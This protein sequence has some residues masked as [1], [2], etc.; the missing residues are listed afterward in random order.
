MQPPFSFD[1]PRPSEQRLQLN[2]EQAAIVEL[3]ASGQ[4][5][6][7]GGVGGTG[8][9]VVFKY[10]VDMLR[11]MGKSVV[12]CAS[13]GSAAANVNGVTSNCLFGLRPPRVRPGD[14]GDYVPCIEATRFAMKN[15]LKDADAL[16]LDEA[17][18]H[19]S[20]MFAQMDRRARRLRGRATAH[21]PFGGMQVVI[22]GDFAQMPPVGRGVNPGTI[23][24]CESE[25]FRRTVGK[26]MFILKQQ[27]RQADDPEYAEAL[28][29]IRQG[30]TTP[31]IM[32]MLQSRQIK[33]TA[34]E[35][36]LPSAETTV[37][38]FSLKA[39]AAEYNSKCLAKLQTPLH[40][41]V[42]RSQSEPGYEE[43]AAD[44]MRTQGEKIELKV[45]VP[46][47]LTKNHKESKLVNGDVGLVVAVWN[48][49]QA[50]EAPKCGDCEFCKSGRAVNEC[51]F[52]KLEFGDESGRPPQSS[53]FSKYYPLVRFNRD[54]KD[55]ER[56]PE[57][58]IMMPAIDWVMSAAPRGP[59]A[60]KNARKRSAA[61]VG[62]PSKGAKAMAAAAAGATAPEK[63][64]YFGGSVE[65]AS[66]ERSE[67][68][69]LAWSEQLPCRMAYGVTIH[70]LQGK[71]LPK[72]CLR[73][74]QI[75]SP[76]QI[77]VALSRVQRLADITIVGNYL[78]PADVKAL[79]SALQFEQRCRPVLEM[80]AQ[81]DRE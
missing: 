58:F 35:D 31:A 51:R 63:S 7:F 70:W 48:A 26:N 30:Q 77:Y 52:R 28:L 11:D 50:G 78:S 32:M 62:L 38:A 42:A 29:T 33:P 24:C 45:G 66:A 8:K 74:H 40:A 1:V 37:H 65:P 27:M 36:N 16:F 71:T 57:T 13:T 60:P 2:P 73:W 49:C 17:S 68:I 4:N 81:R 21:L 64:P 79:Q 67:P 20:G 61:T 56:K 41:W 44:L 75:F 23:Q 80:I 55:P 15:Q 47:M 34:N 69:C 53:P 25:E 19:G 54:S 6:Y 43:L 46:I 72:L 22:T 18:M 59:N 12:V 76:A 5:C 9:S 39:H 10:C 3:V 14:K